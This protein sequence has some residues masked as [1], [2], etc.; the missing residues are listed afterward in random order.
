[1]SDFAIALIAASLSTLGSLLTQMFVS[2]N[3]RRQTYDEKRLMALLEVRQAV[4]E[5]VG[6]WYAWAN[7]RLG[8]E[9]PEACASLQERASQATH[10]AWY[11]TRVFEMYFPTMM[12]S[13]QSMRDEIS[14][15]KDEAIRQ[16]EAGGA[17]DNARFATNQTV[18]M[19]EVVAK[20]RKILGYPS[21]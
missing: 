4:E 11:S 12:K 18:D 6:R 2:K 13:S 8:Q 20:A 14:R 1:M 17:F 9:S 16:V 5:A 15:C 21:V 10:D 3:S 19:D 7:A